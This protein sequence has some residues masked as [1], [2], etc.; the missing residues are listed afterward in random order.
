MTGFTVCVKFSE[1]ISN[2][3][4]AIE[5]VRVRVYYRSSS[6]QSSKG[7]NSNCRQARVIFHISIISVL[8]D[9]IGYVPSTIFQL[10][11]DESSWVEPVLS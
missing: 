11:R 5:W 1:T 9:L 2:G 8:F 4:Q 3:F 6:F 10:Y 7:Y